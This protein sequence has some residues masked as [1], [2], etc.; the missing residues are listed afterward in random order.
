MTSK[1]TWTLIN[2]LPKGGQITTT[3][4]E[5][6]LVTAMALPFG[7]E[8]LASDNVPNGFLLIPFSSA[9]EEGSKVAMALIKDMEDSMFLFSIPIM[10]T[11]KPTV[12]KNVVYCKFLDMNVFPPKCFITY[13]SKSCGSNKGKEPSKDVATQASRYPGRKRPHNKADVRSKGLVP[14]EDTHTSTRL[15]RLVSASGDDFCL[16]GWYPLLKKPDIIFYKHL[17]L[18]KFKVITLEISITLSGSIVIDLEGTVCFMSKSAGVA[19]IPTIATKVTL[20]GSIDIASL[21]RAGIRAQAVLFE[22]SL[23]PEAAITVI[24]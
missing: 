7:A 4:E 13:K 16:E 3:P 6:T 8:G 21:V 12:A 19:L 15:D 2:Q 17:Y 24:F 11:V 18:L 14:H 1:S 9:T 22:T 10:R 5:Q 23:I 20:E